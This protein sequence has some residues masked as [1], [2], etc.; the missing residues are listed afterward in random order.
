M[1]RHDYEDQIC[2]IAGALEIVG[3]RWSLLIIRDV[4]LGLRRFDELQRHL[5][6]ARNVLQARLE[7][8]L[9]HGVL[10]KRR[11]QERPERFE[12]FLTEKG[13]DLWPTIVTLMQWGDRYAAPPGGPAVLIEHR[14]CGG[15]VDEHRICE[16]CGAR[17]GA[18][19]ARAKAG[20]GAPSDHPILVRE[21]ASAA[22]ASAP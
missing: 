1:L 20:P 5:G 2:S 4:L 6:I 7:R 14:G 19:D 13:L 10:E 16:A 15:R 21:A 18:R 3:E 9:D 17:V 22:R 11:Y 12:Y 8:L